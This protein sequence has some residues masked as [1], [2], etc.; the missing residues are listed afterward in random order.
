MNKYLKKLIE[1]KFANPGKALDL[2]AGNF[3]DVTSLKNLGWQAEGVDLQTGTDLEK[4]YLSE[5]KPYDLVYSNYVIHKLKDK[6]V[7]VETI[8]HNLKIGGWFLICTFDQSDTNSSSALTE[9]DLKKLC[10]DQGF[11]NTSTQI[12]DH[13]DTEEGHNHW[14]KILVAQGQ[15]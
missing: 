5:N 1:K 3:E 8:F 4:P 2:G 14:H 6:S 11:K 7:L 15:K 12:I 13:F 10:E 9:T